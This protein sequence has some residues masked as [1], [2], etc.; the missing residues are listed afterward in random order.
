M[1]E[2]SAPEATG[3]T[4]ADEAP[5]DQAPQDP[6]PRDPSPRDRS[7]AWPSPPPQT[8]EHAVALLAATWT[9]TRGAA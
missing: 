5:C 7:P 9:R 2:A 4:L 6:S 8:V 3:T 1:D